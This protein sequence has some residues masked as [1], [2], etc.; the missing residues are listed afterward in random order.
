MEMVVVYLPVAVLG[1]GVPQEQNSAPLAALSL[2][3]QRSN[4]RRPDLGAPPPGF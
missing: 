3:A 2:W 4:G 1:A